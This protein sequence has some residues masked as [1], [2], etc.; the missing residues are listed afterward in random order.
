MILDQSGKLV[1]KPSGGERA[2]FLEEESEPGNKL[3]LIDLVSK[4]MGD[5]RGYAPLVAGQSPRRGG[6]ERS[7]RWKGEVS[8]PSKYSMGKVSGLMKQLA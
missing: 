5:P 1:R 3:S 6:R 7:E 8:S 4:S 2:G